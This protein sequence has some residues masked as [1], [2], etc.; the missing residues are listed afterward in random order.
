MSRRLGAA[1]ALTS[2]LVLGAAGCGDEG[3]GRL[4]DLCTRGPECA[5]GRCDERTCKARD[6][7]GPGDPCTHYLQC[8]S[9]HCSAGRCAAGL[10]GA[11]AP[12]SDDLQ[13]LAGRCLEGS[14]GTAGT[15]DGG[16]SEA[17]ATD[18]GPGDATVSDGGPGDGAAGDLAA[19]GPGADLSQGPAA[20]VSWAQGFG[21]ASSDDVGDLVIDASG[22][23]YLTGYFRETIDFGGQTLRLAKDTG[24]GYVAS[25]TALGVHRW[26]Q[27]L[28][29]AAD[30][31][32]RGLAVGTDGYLY[33]T[34]SDGGLLLARYELA[35][36][37]TGWAR[38]FEGGRGTQLLLDD[39]GNLYL[40]GSFSGT[41]DLGGAQPL[42]STEVGDSAGFIASFDCSDGGHRWS[43]R[44]GGSGGAG[45]ARDSAGNLFLA[46]R[47]SS[48]DTPVDFGG[49]AWTTLGTDVVVASYAGSDGTH[50]WSNK[51]GG[52]SEDQVN[53]LA[54]DSQGN[55]YI[56][57]YFRGVADFGGGV[58]SSA[59]GL[60]G[61]VASY[62]GSDGAHRWSR[63]WGGVGDEQGQGLALHPNGELVLG[64][65]FQDTAQLGTILL[66]TAGHYDVFIAHLDPGSGSFLRAVRSGGPEEELPA[67]MALDASGT[68]HLAG[69]FPR[70]AD[71]GGVLL[72]NVNPGLLDDIFLLQVAP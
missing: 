33:L 48:R 13:C 40:A 5:S 8:R 6:P 47:L 39:G 12:C 54:V 51:Y 53:G 36:G 19:D 59:G 28:G 49:D 15:T 62:R 58:L 43:R 63:K 25:F 21:G 17:G 56:T 38:T 18:G 70:T 1:L 7:G 16:A 3:R 71:F 69:T 65:A 2:S 11:G 30:G 37:A 45:L 31:A 46:A 42:D 67:V 66:D 64:G 27:I 44:A 10:R 61:F 24:D 20:Q 35:T 60:E 57:G 32:G 9:E 4:G 14:C 55:L 34:G 41:L 50:R 23:I 29:G 52:W 26:S 68:S 72:E 22:N